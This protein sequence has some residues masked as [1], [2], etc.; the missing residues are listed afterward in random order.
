[1]GLDEEAWVNTV[2]ADSH[3]T[4]ADYCER[5]TRGLRPGDCILLDESAPSLA[6]IGHLPHTDITVLT[7]GL[8][9]AR[10]AMSGSDWLEIALLPGTLDRISRSVMV[11]EDGYA[12]VG[13]RSPRW[14]FFGGQAFSESLGLLEHQPGLSLTKRRLAALC[15]L[16]VA[17]LDSR[18][19]GSFAVYPSVPLTAIA[20]IHVIN[21][22]GPSTWAHPRNPS[23]SDR[24][25]D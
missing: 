10:R 15:E 25:S 2:V 3:D 9:V 14:G 12:Y 17:H 20:Q 5:I 6:I 19:V 8:D 13:R 7:T 16:P 11:T 23:G 21:G 24:T 18:L 22:P 4:M 1:M